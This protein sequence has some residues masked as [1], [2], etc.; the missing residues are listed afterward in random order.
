MHKFDVAPGLNDLTGDL[1]AEDKPCRRRGTAPHHVLV[2]P[3]D[4]GAHHFEYHA[5][6]APAVAQSKNWEIDGLQLD[7]ARLNVCNTPRLL[8]TTPPSLVLGRPRS[9]LL[10]G[11]PVVGV[12]WPEVLQ[13]HQRFSLARVRYP[14]SGL[15]GLLG[16]KEL[17]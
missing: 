6:V 3:A 12:L 5:V 13:Y 2:A 14:N 11:E 17:I 4:I 1:V 7:L 16:H 9:P 15:S 10:F 8:S